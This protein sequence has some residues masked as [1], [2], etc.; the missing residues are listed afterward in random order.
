M[1]RLFIDSNSDYVAYKNLTDLDLF[2]KATDYSIAPNR[3]VFANFIPFPVLERANIDIVYPF[4]DDVAFRG[5]TKTLK[6]ITLR[7]D[8]NTQRMFITNKVFAGGRFTQLKQVKLHSHIQFFDDIQA[9]SDDAAVF[10]NDIASRAEYLLLVFGD[11]SRLILS[12][13]QKNKFTNIRYLD[14]CEVHLS[15][16]DVLR[17]VKALPLIQRLKSRLSGL[18]AFKSMA[19]SSKRVSEFCRKHSRINN[20]FQ[21]WEIYYFGIGAVSFS[22]TYAAFLSV[23]CPRFTY[24]FLPC[25]YRESYYNELLG[26][27]AGTFNEYSDSLQKLLSYRPTVNTDQ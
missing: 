27:Q 3:E 9:L 22:S 1:S 19:G 20:N 24:L 15:V 10:I 12:D 6:S 25:K 18:P 13:F 21:Q 7:I 8:H 14:I 23:V 11:A 17:I 16:R 5:N 2:T 4:G 26:Y